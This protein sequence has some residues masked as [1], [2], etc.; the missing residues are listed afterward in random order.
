MDKL[1][2]IKLEQPDGSYSESI[3]LSAEAKNV[4]TIDGESVQLKLDNAIYKNNIIDNLNSNDSEQVLSA[5]QGNKLNKNSI[6]AY[7]PN[8]SMHGDMSVL[9]FQSGSEI[10]RAIIDFLDKGDD[11]YSSLKTKLVSKGLTKFDY[12][13]VS[14]YHMDHVGQL[15]NMLNDSDFDFSHCV[16][17][18]P[19]TPDYSR[20]IG[21]ARYIPEKEQEI[22]QALTNNGLQIIHPTNDTILN[23]FDDINITF[24][25]CNINDF[26]D[27]YNETEYK[28]DIQ[29]D[30]TIYNNFSMVVQVNH[31]NERMLFTGDIEKKSQEKIIEQGLQIPTLLK[32]EHHGLHSVEGYYEEYIKNYWFPKIAVGMTTMD[33]LYTYTR[34]LAKNIETYYT[35]YSGDIE[36]ISTGYNLLAN[37]ENGRYNPDLS[38]ERFNI[39]QGLTGYLNLDTCLLPHLISENEDLND[40][41]NP[42]T[43]ACSSGEITATLSNMAP[44]L[45]AFKLIVIANTLTSRIIQY[46]IQNKT[47][48]IWYRHGNFD[49]NAWS[50]SNW[51]INNSLGTGEGLLA[52][53]D[54]NTLPIGNYFSESSA[55]TNTILNKPDGMPS[56]SF[57]L[58]CMYLNHRDDRFIQIIVCNDTNSIYIRTKTG[59]NWN[60]WSPIDTM[61]NILIPENSSL[62]DL[63][64]G[65]WC[66]NATAQTSTL[67]NV[68]T[69]VTSGF[70]LECRYLTYNNDNRLYQKLIP[71]IAVPQIYYRTK[72]SDTWGAWYKFTGTQV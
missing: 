65:N 29:M 23:V 62:N 15:L 55:R 45:T 59:D 71:N 49:N 33:T 40:Y 21:S 14:H 8:T 70:K 4:N 38:I 48:K 22:I 27:Y 11:K 18:L 50:F 37:S 72:S 64:V 66:S 35:F 47:G 13:F 63:P 51:S 34:R 2:Y 24:L 41:I 6:T 60:S 5:K 42:G 56:V 32:I 3:P 26:A 57:N 12:A 20:F 44:F 19:I 53:T 39:P 67:S 36:V 10:K 25:N 43:Y 54:L 31:K 1:K 9:T 7:F 58:T 16:F 61:K 68:P 69:G 52:N 30:V 46:A 28:E 17:Y